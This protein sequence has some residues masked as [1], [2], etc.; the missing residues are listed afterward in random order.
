MVLDRCWKKLRV[1]GGNGAEGAR[2]AR[3]AA[4]HPTRM[5][6]NFLIDTEGSRIA[7]NLLQTQDDDRSY[8]K[9]NAFLGNHHSG[10]AKTR[11]GTGVFRPFSIVCSPVARAGNRPCQSP[12]RAIEVRVRLQPGSHF[13]QPRWL[14]L[15]A[16]DVEG[17]R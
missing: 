14:H 12:R 16:R 4:W 2:N 3:T 10:L 6:G 17:A 8:S 7:S 1:G 13:L 9:R 15:F 5:Q 11:R